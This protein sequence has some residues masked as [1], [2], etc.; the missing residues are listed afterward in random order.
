[1]WWTSRIKLESSLNKYVYK[2]KF[3]YVKKY[4]R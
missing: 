1:M 4:V 2:L 3:I